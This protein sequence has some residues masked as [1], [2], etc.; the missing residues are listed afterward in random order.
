MASAASP[1]GETRKYVDKTTG[2]VHTVTKSQQRLA[3]CR[4]M[5]L[6]LDPERAPLPSK[7][8]KLGRVNLDH[9]GLPIYGLSDE[10][11]KNVTVCQSCDYSILGSFDRH[12]GASNYSIALRSQRRRVAAGCPSA[13]ILCC[14]RPKP[15]RAP[16]L[17][18]RSSLA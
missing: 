4:F 13:P 15:S 16:F 12:N 2:I 3:R 5:M 9:P 10:S 8:L 7:R 11:W 18:S 6:N 1:R 14:T 17:P